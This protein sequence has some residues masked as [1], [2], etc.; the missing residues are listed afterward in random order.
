MALVYSMSTVVG[1]IDVLAV[2]VYLLRMPTTRDP[3][4]EVKHRRYIY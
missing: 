2:L 3:R 1:V 4:E